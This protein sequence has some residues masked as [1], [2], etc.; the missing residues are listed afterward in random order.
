MLNMLIKSAK[1]S[2][3]ISG[4]LAVHPSLRLSRDSAYPGALQSGA[5]HPHPGRASLQHRAAASRPVRKL[6]HP[7]CSGTRKTGKSS[8]GF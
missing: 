5:D 2:I 8:S 3:S 1:M 6:R 4:F 7:A